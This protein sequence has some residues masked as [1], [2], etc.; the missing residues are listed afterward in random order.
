MGASIAGEAGSH[1]IGSMSVVTPAEE[2]AAKFTGLQVRD[3]R[4]GHALSL[5]TGGR[6]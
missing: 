5:S 3:W 1:E 6:N 2:A 4:E